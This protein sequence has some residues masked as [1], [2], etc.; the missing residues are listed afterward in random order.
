MSS[1]YIEYITFLENYKEE[2]E[3]VLNNEQEKRQALLN[4][5]MNRVNIMLQFQQAE[6]MKL[7][8]FESKRISFQK[9]LGLNDVNYSELITKIDDENDRDKI[10]KIFDEIAELAGEIKEQNKQS[11]DI[12]NNYLKIL[13]RVL[14]KSEL[15]EKEGLYGPNNGLRNSHKDGTS[16]N[17]SI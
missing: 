4:S 6:T 9:Q 14:N 11:V 3:L 17:G 1:K 8:T 5:D 16:L 7:K 13:G 12:A 2:L 10:A 15:S